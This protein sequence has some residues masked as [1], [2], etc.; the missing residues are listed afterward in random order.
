MFVY[1][2][3]EAPCPPNTLAYY[4]HFIHSKSES[5]PQD[6]S[7]KLFLLLSYNKNLSY[8]SEIAKKLSQ[9]STLNPFSAIS[10]SF[11]LPADPTTLFVLP[12]SGT[13]SPWSSKATDIAKS[14]GL[15]DYVSR[16]ERGIVY[17]VDPSKITNIT[18]FT[19]QIHDR[20]TQ[21]VLPSIPPISSIFSSGE[22]GQLKTVDILSASSSDSKQSPIEVLS[23][24]NKDWGLALASDEIDY[25]VNAFLKPTEES[26]KPRNPTDAELMMFA[27]V[28]SE[29]CRHK[30]FRASWEIDGVHHDVSLFD[31]IR[32]TYKKNP[33]FIHSAYSDNAAV[34][35]GHVGKR[36]NPSS[37]GNVYEVDEEQ[38]HYVVKVETH[39]HPTAVS[40]FPGAA[41]GA[42][43]E[44]RDEGAVGQGSK[45]SAG[46]VGFIV[47]NLMIPDFVQPWEEVNP[48]KP[49]HIASALDI[50]IQAP[51]GSA[52]FGNEFG[53]PGLTGF[54]RTF[55]ENVQTETGDKEWRGYHKPIMLAG[56]MGTIRP[57]HVEK[58]KIPPGSPLI[59]LGGPSMLIGL[60]GGAASSMAAGQSSADL[61]FA[62]VQRDN[63]EMQ[64][65]CQQV[66]DKCTNLGKENPIVS[67]HDV[68][69]GG[70]SNALP[71]LVHDSDLGAIFQ[72]RDVPCDDPRMS[73]MEIWC[74]ESQE[75][76]VMGVKKELLPLFE[77][78]CKRERCPFAVVGVATAEKRLTLVDSLLKTST[79]IDLPMS[80]LFGKPPKMHR[81]AKSVKP[82]FEEFKLPSGTTLKDAAFR[83]LRLPAVGSKSF[84]VTIGDRT[85]TGLVA[86][87]Q[88]VGPWQT[89]VAN[90]AVTYT[91]YEGKTGQ[92]MALGE[93]TPLALVS[94]AASARMAVAESLT[95]L[96]SAY[97]PDIKR[98]RLSANWMSAASHDGEGAAMYEAVKAIGMEFCPNLGITIPVGKDSMS[99]KSKWQENGKEI[100]VTAP[101]SLIITAYAPVEDVTLT[102]TPEL[103]SV[104]GTELV[105]IDLSGGNQR[106]GGSCLAQVYNQI[107]SG[108]PDADADIMARFWTAVQKVKVLK[109]SENE[110]S[111]VLAYHDRSDGGLFTTVL[112]M[113]FA[114]RVGCEVDIS[115]LVSSG[116]DV[117]SAI[118][119]EEL[120]VVLQVKTVDIA[121]IET[122]FK[123]A[124]FP[125]NHIHRIGK[126]FARKDRANDDLTKTDKITFVYKN[127]VVLESSRVEFQRAWSEVSYKMQSIRDNAETSA[128]EFSKILDSRDPGIF[129]NLKFEIP[130][131]IPLYGGDRRPKIAILRE[132]GVNGH[133]EMAYAFHAAGFEAVDVHMTELLGGKITLNKFSGVA[134]PGGFSY[135]DVLGAGNGWAQSIL[136]NNTAQNEISE[137]LKRDNTFIFGVCNGCQMVSSMAKNVKW[138]KMKHWPIFTNNKS[139]RF[140]ARVSMVKVVVGEKQSKVFFSGMQGSVIPVAVAHGEGRATFETAESEKLAEE[141]GMIALKYVDGYGKIAGEESYPSNPNGSAGGIAGVIST[142][143]RVVAMMPHPE[144][145]IR[146]GTNT[147]RDNVIKREAQEYSGWIKINSRK[148]IHTDSH[149]NIDYKALKNLSPPSRSTLLNQLKSN[150]F[151]LL[152]I[153]GG[154]TGVGCAV[155]AVTRG[156][157][158]ALVERDDFSSGTSSRS[159][160]LVHGG[161][162]YL[163]KA[164]LEM[165][166]E[167]FKLVREALHE[168][169]IFLKIA[170]YLS[171]QL[172]IMVPIYQFWKI[173]YYWFGSKAYDFMAGGENLSKSYFLSKSK[174]L[175]NFPM[176]KTDRLVGAMVY[177]DGAHNDSR[178]NVS[179]ALTA[180]E[181]GAVVANHVEVLDLLK[182]NEEGKVCGAV[183]RDNLSG[184]RWEIKAKGIINATGPFTDAIRK[185]DEGIQTKEIV[186]PS[187]G[188]HIILPSYYSPKHMGLLDPAT[189]DGRVIFFLPWQGNVI[190]GTTDSPT[191]VTSDPIPNEED[192][193]WILKEVSNYLSSDI[194]VRRGDVLAAW[195][196]IR[197]LVRDPATKNTSSL[198]RNH[199][200]NV[201]KNGLLTIAGG[202][203]TTYR[204]M[205]EE[206]VNTAVKVFGLQPTGPCVTKHTELVGSRNWS[207]TMFIKLIQN[208][209][210]EAEI[211]EHLTNSYGDRSWIVSSMA[212]PSSQSWPIYGRRLSPGYPYLE[213][214]VRYAC[215]REYAATAID[216]LARR[217]RLAFLDSRA[218]YEA[219][220][221]VVEIMGQELN[222]SVE[223]KRLEYENTQNFLKTMG[224]Y[225]E[226]AKSGDGNASWDEAVAQLR[227]SFFT[228]DEFAKLRNDFEKVKHEGSSMMP[229]GKGVSDGVIL[230]KDLS[231]LLQVVLLDV[232]VKSELEKVVARLGLGNKNVYMF[233]DLLEI[234]AA[235]KEDRQRKILLEK[236]SGYGGSR[237]GFSI[238]ESGG[239]L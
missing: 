235:I 184:E 123:D 75:R 220:P 25:L 18:E 124:G 237:E 78:I 239:G 65:R 164:I 76:Y 138:E 183:V 177:Y 63:P 13:I 158:V 122:E 145:V 97:I 67:I 140:E 206:T 196:G 17:F 126:V 53:R 109:S 211:A 84:L 20:M 32:N 169:S 222:W 66:I 101:L 197:P 229:S 83:L 205:A 168:R 61:D 26:E 23:S 172:P 134:M 175:E 82:K 186:S 37:N 130:Q 19:A 38:V 102:L 202:K 45:S 80:T 16:I 2:G 73:P 142:D 70:L 55:L 33:Q 21:S 208:F 8:P 74:N 36:F 40:P 22:P 139:G 60:G 79:P 35:E 179:L 72:L 39:N 171:Y 15:A 150:Q 165:D 59:V 112:E 209:G 159:T 4:I 233:N 148:L 103:K 58:Q 228:V 54:F 132:Q 69:A 115:E 43:G 189:S 48:G 62:S 199:M 100:S 190:V 86:R 156:L 128:Q 173:P 216:V 27:Q 81:I 6:V 174:A 77:E 121:T 185:M 105:F 85:V 187:A 87:D 224:L 225:F 215:R 125:L 10:T 234:A 90:V 34:L 236:V 221:R 162:R 106:M 213:A 227:R 223:R 117:V 194:K 137:F 88:M 131:N 5:L 207:K 218:A 42:G 50:M 44:I 9:F 155:D 198:V 231:R 226:D 108:A 153:G 161:V 7:D 170:P 52:A 178:M 219:L 157:K 57:M 212:E 24:A 111:L 192:I 30:I 195:S 93:K 214:E 135:G 191:D 176:L 147:W 127:E 114:G 12:R 96:A 180:I 99:M 92:A 238:T 200:I 46:L 47:S 3:C 98:V 136:Q 56:G 89:P 1:A 154:A 95:N 151:D 193:S 49:A 104:N 149:E 232:P 188:V 31:M 51:L 133:V 64:R 120:G 14:C 160:K 210:L 203:W 143:G 119:N 11:P 217:L 28:N 146:S 113:S 167:Q 166:Y 181:H 118:F 71:E 230:K 110:D 182:A 144:R 107:G 41:T 141:N 91:G 116:G 204:E 129:E 94:A 68:G 29:H 163:E 152:I 201:S